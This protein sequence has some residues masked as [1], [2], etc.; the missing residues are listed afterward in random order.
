MD[1]YKTSE[2]SVFIVTTLDF[3]YNPP[4][5]K[6]VYAGLSMVD[7]KLAFHGHQK[8]AECDNNLEVHWDVAEGH[9]FHVLER[10]RR[11]KEETK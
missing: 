9:E 2:P 7:S 3:A 1:R 4:L 8:I 10:Q 11:I 6:I 5:K